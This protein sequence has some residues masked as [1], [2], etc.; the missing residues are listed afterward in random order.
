MI[1]RP[2]SDAELIELAADILSDGM[3][4]LDARAMVVLLVLN[5]KLKICP[6]KSEIA[7]MIAGESKPP[8]KQRLSRMMQDAERAGYFIRV[9]GHFDNRPG[10][11]FR[12][13]FVIGG[14][15]EIRTFADM[16]AAGG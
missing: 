7:E 16:R 4:P 2:E 1:L 5:K 13:W 3:I 12:Y 9:N 15:P 8:T 14:K 11:Q 10:R 6:C